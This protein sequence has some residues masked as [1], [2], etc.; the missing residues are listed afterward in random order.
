M[1]RIK[2]KDKKRTFLLLISVL[3]VLLGL[4]IRTE[5][6]ESNVLADIWNP[7]KY[8]GINEIKP[9]MDAYCLTEYG[10]AGIEKFRMKVIDVVPGMDPGRDMIL[11]KGLDERFI[12][13][14]PVA[15]CS[16]SPVYIDG[17]LAGA[18]AFAWTFSKDPLYGVTPI[19]EMLK[20]G[21][22]PQA[23]YSG[24][25]TSSSHLRNQQADGTWSVFDFTR[26]ID[27]TEIDRRFREELSQR[28]PNLS[29]V[30]PLPCP[31]VTSG[32]PG[33]V[34]EE[35]D[36]LVR[37]FGLM[38][39]AGGGMGSGMAG[40]DK[41]VELA[42][43]SC[44]AVPLVSGD[45]TIA[46]VGTTTEVVND[47]VYGFGHWLLG[48]GPVNLPMATG[49][50]HTVVS[51]TYRSFKVA[52]PIETVGALTAD[53]SMAVFGQVGTV[54]KT[55]P[56]TIRIDRY[57]DTQKRLYNCRVAY[58][59]LLTP[60]S[61]RSAVAGAALQLGDFPP[62][63]TVEYKVAIGIEDGDSIS[64]ENV[65]TAV[66]LNELVAES[67]GSV[68]LFM[69]NPYKEVGIESLDFDIR[70]S[71]RS[72]VSRIW[73]V[74]LSDSKV[75]AGE[76]IDIDVVVESVLAGKKKYQGT[77][78]IPE[79]LAPGG[80]ELAV[81]GSPYY[82]RFL[83]KAVPYKFIAESVPSLLE[84][85]KFTLSIGRDRLYFLLILPPQGVAIEQ[86]ELPDLPGTRTLVLQSSKRALNIRPYQQW[87]EHSLETDKVI[88]NRKVL[89]IIV[90]K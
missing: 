29:G 1:F 81:C 66:G 28:R 42:P 76:K 68:M 77:L 72:V 51:S 88:I 17:R 86:S 15:G 19:K 11:V 70:I 14:G 62:D 69:N 53:E 31:L 63:H 59:K 24:Q 52:S 67:I 22:G 87:I 34:C 50:V 3:P 32:L 83:T 6:A 84:A 61:I 8:I 16:G 9:G 4:Q 39:V 85:L 54:A 60:L 79:D 43:G 27:F 74:D 48:Y 38:V 10:V 75:K 64:F 49:V 71:P 37:P 20:V 46:T 26:P 44:L 5:A 12:H 40:S 73:S 80:Y 18:L 57:N 35:L 23:G 30:N 55:I 90:E 13:T 45:I 58:N 21:M 33:E 2:V 78:E 7:V 41:K 25:S 47:K 36:E 56:L 65:S 89:K 82:E